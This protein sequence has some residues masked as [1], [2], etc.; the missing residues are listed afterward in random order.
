MSQRGSRSAKFIGGVS[1][2]PNK[3]KQNKPGKKELKK[4]NKKFAEFEVVRK[5]FNL[6]LNDPDYLKYLDVFL[7]IN[8]KK[9]RHKA[10]ENIKDFKA[11][12]EA[13][14]RPY[15]IETYFKFQYHLK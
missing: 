8:N 3:F 2:K 11:K 14:N 12:A 1:W 13:D 15:S 4:D 7:E 9:M 5:V 6:S 10:I